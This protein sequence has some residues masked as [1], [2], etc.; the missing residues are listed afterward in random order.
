MIR[1]DGGLDVKTCNCCGVAKE[2]SQFT[3]SP[4][5]KTGYG[6]ECRECSNRKQ[7][8]CR[9]ANGDAETKRYEKTFNGY[10]MR[11]YRNMTSRVKGI[12]K[13]KAHL[14]EGLEIL[15]KDTFYSW[16]KENEDYKNL[17]QA[18]VES[19]Y[20]HRLAPSID[21]VD[22]SGGY[23]MGNIRW[24]PHWLNSKLGN[25]SRRRQGK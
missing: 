4:S 14:Y 18:W 20:E 10:L 13:K 19:G 12:L 5:T 21:R 1:G 3:K 11:T 8:E 25:E 9:R 15:D 16:S 22:S 6:G 17:Y 24:L 7:R 23:V 2:L